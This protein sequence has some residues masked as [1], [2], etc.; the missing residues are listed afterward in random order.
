MRAARL[1]AIAVALGAPAGA[2]AQ[3]WKPSRHVEFISGSAAGSASDGV[4]RMVERLLHEKKL[5]ETSS[6]VVNKPGGGGNIAWTW[7]NQQP[8]DG[9]VM[10]LVIGNLISNYITGRS[11]LSYTDLAC[12][13]PL[14]SEYTA[15]GVRADS[16]IRDA[17][18]LLARWKADPGA[19]SVSVGTA[20]GGSGHIALALA[21]KEAGAD[22]R[23]MKAVVFPAFSQGLSALLGGHIDMIAN[24]HSSFLA[25]VR[26]GRM[27]IVA[28]AA[29]QRLPGELA[30][31]P[32]WKELGVDAEIEAFRAIAGPK[33]LGK[34]Q[35]DYWESV[36]RTMAQTA[37]WRDMLEK[38]AWI[39]RFAG[40][41]GCQ[42]A[43]RR[44][45]DLMRSGLQ[46]LGLARN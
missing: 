33:G 25:P 4:I 6:S 1:L 23:K 16:P 37:E 24:P 36:L 15:V 34:A 7:V 38:R 31:A 17:K 30:S 20:F 43:M 10:T 11:A 3:G 13:A 42:R 22:P 28:V 35:V 12:V 21:M 18:D 19:L 5:I 14:F 45:Y 2:Q 27:R 8:P 9:H 29:P 32:T 46:E 26:E 40:A 44:Q 41:E 39:D